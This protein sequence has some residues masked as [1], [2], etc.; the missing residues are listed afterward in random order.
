MEIRR[1]E[2]QRSHTKDYTESFTFFFLARNWLWKV[3]KITERVQNFEINVKREHSFCHCTLFV[4]LESQL[5]YSWAMKLFEASLFQAVDSL[6]F[7]LQKFQKYNKT[8]N[9]TQI[10]SHNSTLK[11]NL[12]F[13]QQ[14]STWTT[15]INKYHHLQ[16]PCVKYCCTKSKSRIQWDLVLYK[17]HDV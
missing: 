5:K 15:A 1:R 7:S 12:H 8:E 6:S 16:A 9:Y 3:R 10:V 2:F 11:I 14:V 13:A 17:Q 4:S